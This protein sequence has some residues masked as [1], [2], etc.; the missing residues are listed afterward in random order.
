MEGIWTDFSM[1]SLYKEWTDPKKDTDEAKAEADKNIVTPDQANE[2]PLDENGNVDVPS[3][4]VVGTAADKFGDPVFGLII[5]VLSVVV[6][7]KS[8]VS[9][10]TTSPSTI[11]V[12]FTLCWHCCCGNTTFGRFLYLGLL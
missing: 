1:P 3:E 10:L 9:S 2:L 7:P 8:R 12:T 11:K 4:Q 5:L 6:V